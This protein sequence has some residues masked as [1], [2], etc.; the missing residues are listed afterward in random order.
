MR[1]IRQ[2]VYVE[3]FPQIARSFRASP[4]SRPVQ[5]LRINEYSSSSHRSRM[6]QPISRGTPTRNLSR[7]T[8]E[9]KSISLNEVLAENRARR[10]SR[11]QKPRREVD[12]EKTYELPPLRKNYVKRDFLVHK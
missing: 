3:T 7:N 9:Q 11:I 8:I 1:P 4:S 5:P 10:G 2:T 6:T 12:G